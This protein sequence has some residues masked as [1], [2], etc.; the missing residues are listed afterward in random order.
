MELRDNIYVPFAISILIHSLLVFMLTTSAAHPPLPSQPLEIELLKPEAPK[1]APPPPAIASAPPSQ[2]VAPP[3]VAPPPP[4][5]QMVSPPD[6]PEA[7]PKNPRFLSDKNSRA[8]E[9]MV[10]RGQPAPPAEP[11]KT[12]AKKD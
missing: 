12:A 11:P 3:E 7:A 5:N 9:E 10:K 1:A 8:E 6:S 2:G 4:K